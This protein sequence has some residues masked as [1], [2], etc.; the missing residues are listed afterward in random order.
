MKI[1]IFPSCIYR[2]PVYYPV[3]NGLSLTVCQIFT[4]FYFP[5]K[6]KMAAKSGK[7]LNFY[8]LHRI[9]LQYSVGQKFA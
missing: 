4:I 6:I 5:L 8:L 2:I 9:L 7:K 1:E 3:Q